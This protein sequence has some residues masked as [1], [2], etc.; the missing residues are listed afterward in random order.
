MTK[1]NHAR[2]AAMSPYAK[3]GARIVDMGYSAIPVMPGS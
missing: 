3:D 2:L 1:L